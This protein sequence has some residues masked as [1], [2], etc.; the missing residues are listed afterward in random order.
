V[1][2]VPVRRIV[3]RA[4]AAP[5]LVA[6]ALTAELVVI[7]HRRRGGALGHL[8]SVTTAV[9]HGAS[10]PVAVVPLLS[11]GVRYGEMPLADLQLDVPPGR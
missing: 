11:D 1:S 8:S 4:A 2:G 5:T 10:C 6:A 3:G 9:L 7:G